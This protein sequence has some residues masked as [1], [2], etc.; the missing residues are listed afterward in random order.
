MKKCIVTAALLLLATTGISAQSAQ[1][2]TVSVTLEN[3]GNNQGEILAGLHTA[4]TFMKGMGI[5]NFKAEAREGALS[6]SFEHVPP[7]AYAISV[8]HDL[9]GNFQMD[10]EPNGMPGEPYAMSGDQVKMGPPVFSRV[11]FQVEEEDLELSLRF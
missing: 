3:V 11:R 1:G 8:L 5:Q 7:G 9:N 10:Y 6:F 2:V 4:E